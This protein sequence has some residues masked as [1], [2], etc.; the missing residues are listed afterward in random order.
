MISQTVDNKRHTISSYPCSYENIKSF[1]FSLLTFSIFQ[2]LVN[3]IAMRCRNCLH[4]GY[5]CRGLVTLHSSYNLSVALLLY[6]KKEP[7]L[8][9]VRKPFITP[10]RFD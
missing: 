2:Q 9:V 4:K 5:S 8:F 6:H 7:I 10:S 3:A 1:V